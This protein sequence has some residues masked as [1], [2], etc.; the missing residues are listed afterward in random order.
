MIQ[1]RDWRVSLTDS[2]APK[3][4]GGRKH[5]AGRQ[6]PARVKAAEI[7][8]R[9][10]PRS[11]INRGLCAVQIAK[12]DGVE[13]V[14]MHIERRPCRDDGPVVVEAAG[15]VFGDAPNIAARVQAAALRRTLQDCSRRSRISSR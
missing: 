4:S 2:E 12:T 8:D 7:K 14:D 15:E 6:T 5:P 13:H 9:I 11:R 1:Q 3:R 10:L